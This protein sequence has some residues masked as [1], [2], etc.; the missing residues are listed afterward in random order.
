MD[1]QTFKRLRAMIQLAEETELAIIEREVGLRVLQKALGAKNVQRHLTAAGTR[2]P[3]ERL[4]DVA[5]L[6][7]NRALFEAELARERLNRQHL[8]KTIH[9]LLEGLEP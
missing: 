8:F 1:I 6:Q 7:R 5:A 2:A 3:V 4:N 9:E